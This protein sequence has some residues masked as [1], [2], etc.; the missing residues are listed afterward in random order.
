[1]AL[2]C[3][4]KILK[5]HSNEAPGHNAAVA[6][7]SVEQDSPQTE[8]V[9]DRDSFSYCTVYSGCLVDSNHLLSL[10]Y[11]HTHR[12]THKIM[13]SYNSVVNLTLL[14]HKHRYTAMSFTPL[15]Q[16]MLDNQTLLNSPWLIPGVPS[17]LY[18]PG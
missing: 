10:L 3:S 1:M 9:R 4:H 13:L 12:Y 15:L 11:L 5:A 6:V 18:V 16:G 14:I 2:T 8:R 7:H 17:E